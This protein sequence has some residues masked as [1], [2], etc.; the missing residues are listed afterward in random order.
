MIIKE[1]EN[2][3]NH[4]NSAKKYYNST[5][6]DYINSLKELNQISFL[7]QNIAVI[8]MKVLCFLMLKKYE[9]IIEFYY[10]N[11]KHLDSLFNNIEIINTEEQNEIK[12]IISLAFFNFNYKNKAKLICPDIRD[13]Y[14]YKIEKFSIE[15]AHKEYEKVETG[16]LNTKKV[17][18]NIK[19]E[20]DKNMKIIQQN[21]VKELKRISSNFVDDLFEETKNN[22]SRNNIYKIS[23]INNNKLKENKKKDLSNSK[24]DMNDMN[25]NSKKENIILI[26]SEEKK[27][28]IEN[29]NENNIINKLIKEDLI[30]NKS[31]SNSESEET[32]KNLNENI[33]INN[34]DKNEINIY[35][36]TNNN[37]INNNDKE[38]NK[39]V[40]NNNKDVQRKS[41]NA[42]VFVNPLEFTLS[43]KDNSFNNSSNSIENVESIAGKNENNQNKNLVKV[44]VDDAQYF[45]VKVEKNNNIKDII[46]DY[47]EYINI[48][49]SGFRN[50]NPKRTTKIKY[51]KSLKINIDKY[52]NMEFF[53]KNEK[54]SKMIN[55]ER[56]SKMKKTS[57][58]KSKFILDNK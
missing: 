20:L 31:N 47:E 35:N 33:N 22:Y 39:K 23:N 58:Y 57:F 49:Y 16:R 29:I 48:Y 5:P 24:K 6:S 55:Q 36:N 21:K 14:N 41:C 37:N 18:K 4:F 40:L 9:E 34:N 42:F 12:K 1:K 25:N 19:I 43:P 8:H 30:N 53:E 26:T 17:F 15:I 50:K 45:F 46:D 28:N 11:K 7:K 38:N 27:K 2:D 52:K 32:D 10:I 54:E 3:I 13:E 56:K 51:S 44:E